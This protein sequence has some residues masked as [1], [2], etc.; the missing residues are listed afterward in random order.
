MYS[1]S[2]NVQGKP[3]RHI[4]LVINRRITGRIQQEQLAVRHLMRRRQHLTNRYPSLRG[5]TSKRFRRQAA[6]TIAPGLLRL[7]PGF[8]GNGL[9]AGLHLRLQQ[10]QGI[11]L[12]GNSTTDVEQ[13]LRALP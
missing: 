3:D 13:K 8:A 11:G 6:L 2:T 1:D 10:C 9:T 5:Q 12:R 4:A 7:L